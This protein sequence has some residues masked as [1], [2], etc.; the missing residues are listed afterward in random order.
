M[1]FIHGLI[2]CIK[3]LAHVRK[4]LF[5]SWHFYT[6]YSFL[7]KCTLQ[8][9]I[10]T[11]VTDSPLS[12]SDSPKSFPPCDSCI[13]NSRLESVTK[14]CIE[15]NKHF[16]PDHLQVSFMLD[17]KYWGR[18]LNNHVQCHLSILTTK[19]HSWFRIEPNYVFYV[20]LHVNTLHL[21]PT[22]QL[23]KAR[24]EMKMIWYYVRSNVVSK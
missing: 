24:F 1:D 20:I 4:T 12:A 8:T 6:C 18:G 23:K 10:P 2:W 17:L 22:P 9:D 13:S 3:S 7:C 15:C 19:C 11:T 5:L 16:C 21:H 14:F